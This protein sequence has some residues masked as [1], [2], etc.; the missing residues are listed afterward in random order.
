MDVREKKLSDVTE[1]DYVGHE[2]FESQE[3]MLKTYKKYYGDKVTLDT[4]VK[5][6]KF[7]LI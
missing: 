5:I 4:V 3:E 6:I 2:K 1:E 7:K